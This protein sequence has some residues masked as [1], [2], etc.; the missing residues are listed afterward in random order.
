[1]AESIHYQVLEAI[2]SRLA[3]IAGDGGSTYWYTPDKTVRCT[4][5][6]RLLAD[7]SAGDQIYA[8]RAGEE[9]HQ[10]ETAQSVAAE[11]EVFVLMLRRTAEVDE[12]P[13]GPDGGLKAREQ[14]RMAQDIL[15]KLWS[16]PTLGG[17]VNNV[18]GD[19]LYLDRDVDIEGWACVEAR[20]TV[21]Y[22]YDKGTP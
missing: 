7:P 20:F 12:S 6:D 18:A 9:R 22:S 3:A 14:D 21:F 2:Q 17:L 11:A 13:F 10:E 16:D 1:M 5:Y 4:V 15:R 19:R 8:V